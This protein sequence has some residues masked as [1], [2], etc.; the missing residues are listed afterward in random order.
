MTAALPTKDFVAAQLSL[1]AI[2]SSELADRVKAGQI[3]FLDAVDLA[4]DAAIFS[5]LTDSVGDDWVQAILAATFD[6][7]RDEGSS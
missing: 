3:D 5:G 1:L 7:C 2:R 6:G 4:Y